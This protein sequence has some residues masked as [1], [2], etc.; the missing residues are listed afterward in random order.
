[1][2]SQFLYYLIL[3]FA[4]SGLSICF[5]LKIGSKFLVFLFRWYNHLNPDIKKTPWTK[6][7]ESTLIKTHKVYGN[8]WAEI[9][10]FLHGRY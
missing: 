2:Q 3:T 10:K 7:E 9:A 4:F 1:M 8:S 5:S 6:E